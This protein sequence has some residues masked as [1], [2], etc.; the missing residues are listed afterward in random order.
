MKRKVFT[1]LISFSRA[2]LLFT[3]ASAAGGL[4]TAIS[5]SGAVPGTDAEILGQWE[6][7]TVVYPNP[8]DLS[9]NLEAI[10]P[11]GS[12]GG[13]ATAGGQ[14]NVKGVLSYSIIGSGVGSGSFQVTGRYDSETRRLR[15]KASS[16]NP[17]GSWARDLDLVFAQAPDALGGTCVE[18]TDW[19][20]YAVFVR[21]PDAQNAVLRGLEP[22]VPAD[23]RTTKDPGYGSPDDAWLSPLKKEYPDLDVMHTVMERLFSISINLFED[24]HFT[25]TFKVPF[26][27]LSP[28]HRKSLSRSMM[29]GS[30]QLW[31][32]QFADV[33]TFSYRETVTAV[34]AQRPIRRWKAWMESR[35]A[36]L[37]PDESAWRWIPTAE[38]EANDVLRV[39]WPS[40]QRETA[41]IANQARM[42]LA[43]PLLRQASEDLLARA[44]SLE[45]AQALA[46][47][48]QDRAELLKYVSQD[49]KVTISQKINAQRDRMSE[50]VIGSAKKDLDNLGSG[51]DAVNAGN[52]WYADFTTRYAFA[53]G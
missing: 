41:T 20:K 18:R 13:P 19:I 8:L 14:A 34:R 12:A 6:G 35:L 26:D 50:A 45:T 40:E 9:L 38:T 17:R 21:P 10:S 29:R 2:L 31:A 37:S 43:E 42:R 22:E 7:V 46:S 33:G 44:P 51:L 1:A 3:F 16:P 36:T 5:A 49:A 15:L 23:A 48:A 39:L 25:K 47:W 53:F 24:E 11:E 27:E 30:Y 52:R 32:A 28:T 4:F